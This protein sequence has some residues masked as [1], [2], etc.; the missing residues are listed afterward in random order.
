M[1]T[2]SFA[3]FEE[4]EEEIQPIAQLVS[5]PYPYTLP[6]TLP[7]ADLEWR[8]VQSCDELLVGRGGLTLLSELRTIERINAANCQE[9]CPSDST[10]Q[11]E[12][13]RSE[14][15][16]LNPACSTDSESHSE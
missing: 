15:E 1:A 8:G 6:E 2:P 12:P 14:H 16:S 11:A 7:I 5:T 9:R 10:V 4:D 13:V 3:L